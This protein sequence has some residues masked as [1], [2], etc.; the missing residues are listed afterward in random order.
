VRWS[1]HRYG[2]D[3]TQISRDVCTQGD[4]MTIPV[5]LSPVFP[6]APLP[7]IGRIMVG[8]GDLAVAAQLLPIF[9]AL[10][11]SVPM[12]SGDIARAS[13]LPLEE[14]LPRLAR[15]AL[16]LND[17]GSV[18]APLDL[19]CAALGV[20]YVGPSPL[21]PEIMA[22][23]PFRAARAVL[24]DLGLSAWRR[25]VAAERATALVGPRKIEELRALV[26]ASQPERPAVSVHQL[27]RLPEPARDRVHQ[28]LG[29]LAGVSE[30]GE[31]LERR[32][33]ELA[34]Q[35][36]DTE[37]EEALAIILEQRAQQFVKN[38]APVGTDCFVSL[39]QIQAI[40]LATRV[41]RLEYI[42]CEVSTTGERATIGFL[43]L[44]V[45]GPGRIEPDL[46]FVATA[47]SFLARDLP[48]RLSDT[49]KLALVR[50]LVSL[51][52]LALE[53]A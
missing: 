43:G 27:E 39:E 11:V 16:V 6:G 21:W 17:A 35:R 4:P 51:G 24:T 25:Q 37:A 41:R 18:P 47:G 53:A 31:V 3:A 42:P 8:P 50:R 44:T 45:S 2:Q 34:S 33:R 14:L 36:F 9:P 12:T 48:G 15:C 40:G 13:F 7:G 28:M 1:E 23:S 46:R 32:A 29:L 52:L 26:L 10:T 19:A 5:R 22:D 49:G 38:G 20:P 30:Y